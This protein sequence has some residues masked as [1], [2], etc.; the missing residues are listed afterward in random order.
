MTSEGLLS[1]ADFDRDILTGIHLFSV[2]DRSQKLVVKFRPVCAN[3]SLFADE[4]ASLFSFD[5]RRHYSKVI[6]LY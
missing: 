5:K 6:A 2:G 1:H 3:V 4:A